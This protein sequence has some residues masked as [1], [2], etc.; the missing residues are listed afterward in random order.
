LNYYKTR[1]VYLTEFR[2]SGKEGD[3][4]L[5]KGVPGIGYYYLK[6]CD[7]LNVPSI[8]MPK[9]DT[10][11]E[12]NDINPRQYPYIT[13]SRGDI[14]KKVLER[15]FKRSIVMI[16]TAVP[17]QPGKYPEEPEQDPTAP[18]KKTFAEFVEGSISTLPDKEK[19]LISD[20]FSREWEKKT[21]DETSYRT[22]PVEQ[23]LNLKLVLD[24]DITIKTTRW[25]WD[26]Q[27]TQKEWIDNLNREAAEYPVLLR[28]SPEGIKE[29]PL[30]A[31]PY[32]V[33]TSFQTAQRSGNVNFVIDRMM[34][35]LTPSALP[36]KEVK[37]IK[38][39]I[40]Q[41]IKEALISGIL[42]E[43]GFYEEKKRG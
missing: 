42:K 43:S 29:I 32:A 15:F 23:F 22:M 30:S 27:L 14:E 13:I 16:D 9:L 2:H 26:L 4:S 7:P 34:A 33:L 36:E 1:K 17:R 38:G 8:L 35:A 21:M 11:M 41:Q 24:R 25:N 40:I 18:V 31:F 37:N 12:N 19:E 20:I 6:L 28:P 10:P 3:T 5:F 39:M